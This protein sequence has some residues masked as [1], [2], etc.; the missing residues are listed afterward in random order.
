RETS[1][2]SCD[3]YP[4]VDE[5]IKIDIKD[6]DIRIDVF[7]SSGAG[8]QSVNTTDSAVRIT[9]IPSGIVVTN[10]NERSQIKNKEVALS[11][12][13]SKLYQLE[14]LKKEKEIENIKG[15][16][17][18]IDFGSQIRSYFL[19]PYQLVKDHRSGYEDNDAYS[20]LDGNLEHFIRSYLIMKSD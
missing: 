16:Q 17:L 1:F 18:D 13:K 14:L 12:L 6:E 10:Q 9:H 7:H 4:S 11:V 19:Q 2:C 5:N 8:G 20:I 15:K 3:V